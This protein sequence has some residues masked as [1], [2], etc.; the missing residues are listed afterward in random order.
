MKKSAEMG[1][2]V[3]NEPSLKRMKPKKAN[4]RE[5]SMVLER[6]MYPSWAQ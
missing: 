1:F 3:S 2:Y 4:Q 5:N 6:E